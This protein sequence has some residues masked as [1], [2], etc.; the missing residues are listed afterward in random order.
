MFKP[1]SRLSA[2]C[3]A[4]MAFGASA[5]ADSVTKLN[6]FLANSIQTFSP[7]ALVA[8]GL[9]GISVQPLGNTTELLGTFTMPITETIYG[10]S[11]YVGL[12]TAPY[13]GGSIGSALAIERKVL[14]G[15]ANPRITL[16]N[17]RIDYHA[18]LVTADA[19][20]AGQAT[21]SQLPI[22]TFNVARPMAQ[23]LN[24]VGMLS[25]DEKLDNLKMTPQAVS[26]FMSGLKLPTFA[27]PVMQILDFGSLV[28]TVVLLPRTSPISDAPYVA[29]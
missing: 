28:Q 12:G 16:A 26:L 1:S 18:K 23:E 3:L 5:H 27:R 15:A 20:I 2:I 4:A 6:G 9:L 8:Y 22:Y 21:A 14:T 19:T 11:K 17:F 29:K 25:L 13:A 10:P 7:E 24:E